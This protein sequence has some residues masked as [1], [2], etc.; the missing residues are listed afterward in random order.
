MFANSSILFS[1]QIKDGKFAPESMTA[2]LLH[3]YGSEN[4]KMVNEMVD[5]CR[6][7]ADPNECE[8]ASKIMECLHTG[9]TKR[10]INPKTG[11]TQ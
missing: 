7:V 11:L 1:I 2:I 10:K 6:P 5:E 8:L 9:T 4:P 3:Q